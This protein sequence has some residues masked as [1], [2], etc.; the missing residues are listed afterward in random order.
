MVPNDTAYDRVA[1]MRKM[2]WVVRKY[3]QKNDGVLGKMGLSR[4]QVPVLLE[5]GHHEELNQR[6]LAEKIHVTPATISETL[7]QMERSGLIIRFTP[8]TDAR[9]Y[10]VR[11]TNTGYE[12]LHTTIELLDQSSTEMLSRLTDE[13]CVFL[14]H[15][16]NRLAQ[17]INSEQ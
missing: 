12:M 17:N 14:N 1:L 11:L 2:F 4:G 6:E 9:I 10:R 5:L 15:I 8:E 16:F 3:I 13:E 7:K